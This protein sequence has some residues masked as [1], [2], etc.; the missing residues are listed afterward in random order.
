[1]HDLVYG[2]IRGLHD[3][4]TVLWIGGLIFLSFVLI[5]SAK[6]YLKEEDT[7]A[8][9]LSKSIMK[10]TNMIIGIGFIVIIV[11]GVLEVRYSESFQGLFRFGNTYSILLSIKHILVLVMILLVVL[12]RVLPKPQKNPN[13]PLLVMY[14]NTI[15]GIAVVILSGIVTALG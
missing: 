13:P 2:I 6:K 7:G 11:T 12:R 15:I 1:M 4:A 14:I 5:P 3:I 9:S 10:K 8:Q